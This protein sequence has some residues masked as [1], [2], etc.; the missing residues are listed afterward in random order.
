MGVTGYVC[1]FMLCSSYGDVYTNPRVLLELLAYTLVFYSSSDR[2]SD[3][4]TFFS[5]TL[6]ALGRRMDRYCSKTLAGVACWLGAVQTRSQ[7]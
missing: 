7:C 6:V 4:P 2:H 1:V 3:F 5:Q